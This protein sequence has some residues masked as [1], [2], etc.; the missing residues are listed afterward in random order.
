[1]AT[2]GE[3]IG[4][5][6]ERLA[7]LPPAATR[8]EARRQIEVTLNAVEDEM[9]GLAFEAEMPARARADVRPEG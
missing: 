9:S 4:E 3:R 2:R 5:F 6:L 7:A 8:E 1:M